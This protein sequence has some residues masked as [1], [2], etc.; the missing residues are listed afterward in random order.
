MEHLKEWLALPEETKRNAFIRTSNQVGVTS[1]AAEKDWWVV[2]TLAMLFTMD[3]APFLSFKGGTSLSKGWGLIQRLS[4]NIDLALDRSFLGFGENI[5]KTQI[6][7]LRD[8][9]CDYQSISFIPELQAK[10]NVAGF[11]GIEV[12]LRGNRSR[13]QDPIIEVYHPKFFE[14]DG[15]LKPGVVI[16]ISTRSLRE[17]K[18]MKSISSWVGGTFSDMAFADKPITIP[19]VNP[20]RTLLEKVFLLHEE[21]QKQEGKIRVNRMSRHLYDIEKLSRT[22]FAGLALGN[23]DLFQ[24]IVAHRR[25]FNALK[26][27][28]YDKHQRGTLTFLPPASMHPV[29]EADYKE[30]LA[31]MIHEES[32]LQFPALMEQLAAFQ[33]KINQTPE[34]SLTPPETTKYFYFQAEEPPGKAYSNGFKRT[35]LILCKSYANKKR[36]TA[37]KAI[38][39]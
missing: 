30:M 3:C 33:Y 32:P 36:A 2:H 5:S 26:F 15:Y 37:E 24:S 18:T 7:K 12:K 38:T 23:H 22:E 9:T 19:V 27:V 34:K 8:R 21:F 6:G 31:N 11:S 16:E 4:E 20:E 35:G 14:G 29:W 13:D 39:L 25:K 1:E 10:F 28:N 17:P